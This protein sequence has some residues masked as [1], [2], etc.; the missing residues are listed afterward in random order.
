MTVQPELDLAH[1]FVTGVPSKNERG[2][3]TLE[4]NRLNCV[5]LNT[6]VEDAPYKASCHPYRSKNTGVYKSGRI[7]FSISLDEKENQ[8]FDVLK[9]LQARRTFFA[10]DDERLSVMRKCLINAS[11]IAIANGMVKLPNG[12]TMDDLH[13]LKGFKWSWKAG[14]SMCPCSP[15]FT[16]PLLRGENNTDRHNWFEF[17][18]KVVERVN[19]VYD[20]ARTISPAP[21]LDNTPPSID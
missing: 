2:T 6:K 21:V 15:A 5:P 8:K 1:G 19:V 9:N 13:K 10:D 4:V 11:R 12:Y 16:T 18:F 17:C 7:A 20:F 3:H 14:C